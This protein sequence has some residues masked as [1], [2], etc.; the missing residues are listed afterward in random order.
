[1][2][3]ILFIILIGFPCFMYAQTTQENLVLRGEY[4]GQKPPS[5]IPELFAPGI[6]S[7]GA[8]EMSI[9]FSEKGDEIFLLVAR[10]TLIITSRIKNSVWTDFEEPSFIDPTRANY[11]MFLSPDGKKLFFTST[12]TDNGIKDSLAP[13]PPAAI[14]FTERFNGIW[15]KPQKVDFG[16]D[17]KGTSS[18]PSVANN[19]NIYFSSFNNGSVGIYC[20]KYINGKYSTPKCLGDSINNGTFNSHP[21]IAPDESYLLIDSRRKE[22]I[23]GGSDIFISFK[24]ENENWTKAQ[25]IGDKI[26]SESNE[27]RSFVSQ[28]GQYLFFSSDRQVL[29]RDLPTIP[30]KGDQVRALLNSPGNGQQDVYWVSASFIEKLMQIK[31]N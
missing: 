3:R 21:Y 19:G 20:S 26:N 8:N 2:Y 5:N 17:F 18:F 16:S 27:M 9:C 23:V 10:P 22:N 7:T 28:D 1:M 11:Y 13:R 24:D 15:N 30:M 31:F 12:R 14:W 25:N 6:V 29:K 4:L